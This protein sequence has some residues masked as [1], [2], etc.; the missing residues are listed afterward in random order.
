M[1]L[2]ARKTNS[3]TRFQIGHVGFSNDQEFVSTIQKLCEF[4]AT[5]VSQWRVAFSLQVV[6][7]VSQRSVALPPF[8]SSVNNQARKHSPVYKSVDRGTSEVGN[9]ALGAKAEPAV[10]SVSVV[11][12]RDRSGAQR[13]A[14]AGPSSLATLSC[15]CAGGSVSRH[16]TPSPCFLHSQS[17]RK[18]RS[19]QGRVKRKREGS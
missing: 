3:H 8:L 14:H 7:G 12:G 18:E 16:Q 9:A 10:S 1:L 13:A 4:K 2:L 6:N 5:T 15:S 17:R 11:H 19:W